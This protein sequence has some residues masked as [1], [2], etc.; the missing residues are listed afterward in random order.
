MTAD[1]RD[2]IAESQSEAL[3]TTV[4]ELVR[5]SGLKQAFI[6]ERI[7]ITE[8]HMSQMLLGK[9][10]LTVDWA[11]RIVD[12]CRVP[13]RLNI[14]PAE[15]VEDV[16]TWRQRA[17]E[18]MAKAEQLR[19]QLDQKRESLRAALTIIEDRGQLAE[20]AE[21]AVERVRCMAQVWIDTGPNTATG[22]GR[23]LVYA[24]QQ[25]LAALNPAGGSEEKEDPSLPP[26]PGPDPYG[27]PEINT[28][29]LPD[30]GL[31]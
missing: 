14:E 3:R 13:L 23:A 10:A 28:V 5:E 19:A 25:V 16:V 22:E 8:K 31:K 18:A 20:R 15:W 12:V 7:G 21:A 4:R 11:Q 9:A 26:D 27:E 2:Q 24:A 30:E 1:L 6:A 17:T 29:H